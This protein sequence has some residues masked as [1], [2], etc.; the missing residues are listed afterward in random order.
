MICHGERT[1]LWRDVLP[2]HQE[3]GVVHA[4]AILVDQQVLGL[5]VPHGAEHM[6]PAQGLADLEGQVDKLLLGEGLQV[7]LTKSQEGAQGDG[8]HDL[9]GQIEG[10]FTHH[11]L[12]S[13]HDV[14]VHE[15]PAP[16]EPE[17]VYLFVFRTQ[18]GRV[19]VLEH[20]IPVQGL[21]VASVRGRQ[22]TNPDQLLQEEPPIKG[23]TGSRIPY[24]FCGHDSTPEVVRAQRARI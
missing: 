12:L 10:G 11:D 15:P 4:E 7:L 1:V 21:V 24:F 17:Y 8:V 23:L 5:Q 14:A 20:E 2:P 22:W 9:L 19:E 13:G 6:H 16:E 3:V 18:E